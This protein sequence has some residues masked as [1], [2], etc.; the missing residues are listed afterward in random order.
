MD[1]EPIIIK[2]ASGTDIVL[3]V[4]PGKE[5]IPAVSAIL[6]AA[7]P[8]FAAMLSPSWLESKSKEISLPDDDADA[9][10]FIT[11]TLSYQNENEIVTRPRVA[12]EILKI[13]M[14][15]D[16]YD[17]CMA[18]K[19][20][21]DYLLSQAIESYE[22]VVSED[23]DD[24]VYLCAAAYVLDRC[25]HFSKGALD[26]MCYHMMSYTTFMDDDYLRTILPA[27]FFGKVFFTEDDDGFT[28]RCALCD[29]LHTLQHLLKEDSSFING[30]C[31]EKKESGTVVSFRTS[32]RS[33]TR[34]ERVDLIS[35]NFCI[36]ALK[37]GRG[38]GCKAWHARLVV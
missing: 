13:A 1:G 38:V 20:V 22:P 34:L 37:T 30:E 32:L 7:S 17:L 6:K 21:L 2:A 23:A 8:L 10:R 15:V 24:I 33:N 27:Q 12:M 16:K 29:V 36:R 9:M 31:E 19:F 5:Q 11:L 35:F 3:I 18:L 28:L 26:L 14:A 4:G 25:E